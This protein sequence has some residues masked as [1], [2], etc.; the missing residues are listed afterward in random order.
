MV[1]NEEEINADDCIKKLIISRQAELLYFAHKP[2][3]SK[4]ING[5]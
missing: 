4:I 1:S 2:P 5:Q 3:E